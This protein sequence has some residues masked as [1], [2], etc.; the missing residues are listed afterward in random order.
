MAGSDGGRR[1]LL[2][3]VADVPRRGLLLVLRLYQAT[4]SGGLPPACRF[5]PTCSRY[6]YAAIERH[7]VMRG[8]WLAARRLMRCH[9]WGGSGFDPVP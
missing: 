6:A 9:P 5:E 7:G 3:S 4:I 8:G 2:L 1:G